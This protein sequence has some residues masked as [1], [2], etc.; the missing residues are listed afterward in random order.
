M[1]TGYSLGT[2][3]NTVDE[4]LERSTE[5]EGGLLSSGC[6]ER[7]VMLDVVVARWPA[8]PAARFNSA[9]KFNER[10]R[11][12]SLFHGK[13]GRLQFWCASRAHP[14]NQGS[15]MLR[16]VSCS[17]RGTHRMRVSMH[18][19]WTPSVLSSLLMVSKIKSKDVGRSESRGK[20][21][22]I[23]SSDPR[24]IIVCR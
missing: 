7:V 13:A 10:E 3:L 22:N 16:G 6:V 19:F 15:R 24:S 11:G 5:I 21:Y 4:C 14:G 1:W 9:M 2:T 20:G 18:D 17:F 12:R 23:V 8:W